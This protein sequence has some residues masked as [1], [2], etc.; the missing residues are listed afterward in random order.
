LRGIG[1]RNEGKDV[2]YMCVK[3]YD[4]REMIILRGV[5]GCERCLDASLEKVSFVDFSEN[6]TAE[7]GE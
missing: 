2:Q 7:F 5:K 1:E 4:C 3:H 6:I